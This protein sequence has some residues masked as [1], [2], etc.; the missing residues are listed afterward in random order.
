MFTCDPVTGSNSSLVINAN[1]GLGESVVS[2]KA[3]PD[4]VRVMRDPEFPFDTDRLTL[5]EVRIGE[6]KIQIKQSGVC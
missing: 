5:G 4:T 3:D 6:K 2:G 1:F